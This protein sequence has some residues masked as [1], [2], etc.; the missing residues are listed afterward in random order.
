MASHS[1]QKTRKTRALA[2]VDFDE[3]I[4]P[5]NGVI[6]VLAGFLAAVICTQGN[7]NPAETGFFDNGFVQLG[8]VALLMALLRWAV[9][10]LQARMVRRVQLCI[11]FS[12][13]VHLWLAFYL[14]GQYLALL[15]REALQESRRIA[16]QDEPITV[17]DYQWY[18]PDQP[19]LTQSFE[20]PVKAELPE[21]LTVEPVGRHPTEEEAIVERPS[22][23]EPETPQ[24]PPDPAELRRAEL[25]PPERAEDMAGHISRQQWDNL[26]E[27]DETVPLPEVPP[28]QANEPPQPVELEARPTVAQRQLDLLKAA[29]QAAD[30]LL[31]PMTRETQ[32]PLAI[33]RRTMTPLERP[34]DI[35]LTPD[36]PVTLERTS[37]GVRLPSA[38]VTAEDVVAPPAVGG[39]GPSS[40]EIVSS[41]AAVQR[42][43]DLALRGAD[44]AAVGAAEFALGSSQI[45]A[46][47]GQPRAMGN[48]L[49]SV[50]LRAPARRIAR[51]DT[52][53]PLPT[54][55]TPELADVPAISSASGGGATT[56]TPDARATPVGPAGGVGIPTPAWTSVAGSGPPGSPGLSGPVT[57]AQLARVPGEASIPAAWAGGGVPMPARRFGRAVASDATVEVP[58]VA[59]GPASGG[60]ATGPQ[61]EAQ[62]SGQEQQVVGLPGSLRTRPEPGALEALNDTGPRLPTAVAR[63]GFPSQEQSGRLG[64]SPANSATLVKASAGPKLPA[65][66]VPVDDAPVAGAGGADAA[67]GGQPSALEIGPD[68]TLPPAAPGTL[69]VEGIES[70]L[71]A[72][73]PAAPGPGELSSAT[74]P[75]VRIPGRPARSEREF[76]FPVA[77]HFLVK[78]SGRLPALDGRVREV[79]EEAFQQRE[80]ERRSEASRQYGATE[81]SERAVEM[82]L[83]FLARHQFPDG[84]W[85]LDQFPR[86]DQP[87]YA[88]A[89]PGQ[90]HADTAATGLALLTFLGAGYT[91]MDNKHRAAVQRGIDWLLENQQPDGQLF[92]IPTDTD[93]PAR[94]YGHGIGAI[95]LCEAY[96]M[97]K[98]PALREP[99]QRAIQFIIDAQHPNRGGWRYTK[100]DD[101]T[102]WRKESDTSVSGWQL[103]ALKSAQMAGLEVPAEVMQRVGHWLDLAQAA[104]GSQYMYN[105]YAGTS[106]QQRQGRVPNRAMTAEGLLMRMYLGWQRDHPA[107]VDGADYLQQNLPEV[108]TRDPSLRDVYYWYYATQ[109]MFQMQGDHWAAWNERLRPL[110]QES[111]VQEGPLAGSWHPDRP[112]PDRWAHAGGRLYVTSLNLL[113][114]EVYYRHLPL[115]KTLADDV[116]D[117]SEG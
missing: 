84:H 30:K 71:A 117:S 2:A 45:V 67:Q 8:L 4:W 28:A 32:L 115:F 83:D 47:V 65:A 59:A 79:P 73:G 100:K 20:E 18:H 112:V 87:E 114:L 27:P 110:L 9:T 113:M 74:S 60:V 101:E 77:Q 48:R 104:G 24:Q 35:D 50:D 55:A 76:M 111:Q 43:E 105:P 64:E 51:A 99:V 96:G 23:V 3:Q 11:L 16:R 17:P 85:S 33:A 70:A 97:T 1:A 54:T 98:D 81:G 10:W 53:G 39:A 106:S 25:T 107:M 13:L 94:I 21:E 58:R 29:R 88:E 12:L 7:F 42:S 69:D 14:H 95:A 15:A 46:R 102:T 72:R 86:A 66:V 38:A 63:R 56:R 68:T 61:L 44:T 34:S 92:T 52:G 5:I 82:G 31:P 108:S 19:Q 49:P 22:P 116:L 36:R 37:R 91:H 93:R 109:V 62:P 41:R 6:I 89:A 80:P 103:M 90:M 40:I 78:H 26:P 57:V 75:V